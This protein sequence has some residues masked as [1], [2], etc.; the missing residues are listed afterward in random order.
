[1]TVPSESIDQDVPARVLADVQFE[2]P[3]SSAASYHEYYGSG[4]P[5]WRLGRGC[6][7]QTFEVARRIA[8]HH[9]VRPTFL[10]AGG[11]APAMYFEDGGLTLLDPYLPHLA[12]LRLRRADAVDGTVS[13]AVDAYPLRTRADGS[14]APSRLAATWWLRDG[15][16]LLE[17]ARYSPRRAATVTHRAFTF[18]L[19]TELP[20]FPVPGGFARRMLLEPMQNNLSLRALHPGDR[21]LRELVLPFTGRPR[22]ELR[23]PAFLMTKNNQGQVS[24]RGTPGYDEDLAGLADAVRATPEEVTAFV[25]DAAAI[26]DRVVPHTQEWPAYSVEDE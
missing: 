15:V 11:H 13:A 17:Y 18:H 25:T 3:Y 4:A 16:L 24:R 14:A 6:G 20:F 23:D 12:P 9:G 22:A 21:C 2:I 26:Y 8:R 5:P 1:M 7:W 10:Y 19:G